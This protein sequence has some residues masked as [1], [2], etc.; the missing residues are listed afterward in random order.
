MKPSLVIFGLGNPGKEY[1]ETR[2]NAG[3][4]AVDLL[5]KEFG[6]SEW[7][8]KQKFLCELCE[9]RIGVLPVL[10]VKPLTFMNRSGE[11]I[12]KIVD[13]YNLDVTHNII[14]LCDDIDLEP[15]DV[16][17]R[18]TGSAGTHNGLRSIV[19]QF[20]ERFARIRIGVGKQQPGADLSTYVLSSPL[21]GEMEKI[22]EAIATIPALMRK[23]V[24]GED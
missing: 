8:P 11:C 4:W 9:A 24:L 12:H 21:A 3:W 23:Q 10:L 14:V 15:G 13:F 7:Q 20:G 18:E 1:R 6:T 19:E 22:Q 16:R 5:T 17:Y 2:H